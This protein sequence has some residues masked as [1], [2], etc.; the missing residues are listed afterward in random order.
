MVKAKTILLIIGLV[1]LAVGFTVSGAA[2]ALAGFDFS[3][4]SSTSE[5]IEKSAQWTTDEVSLID[6]KVQNANVIVEKSDDELIHI[7]CVFR[8]SSDLDLRLDGSAATVQGSFE[9]SFRYQL[10]HGFFSGLG[11]GDENVTIYIPENAH[12]DLRLVTSNSTISVNGFKNAESTSL[13]VCSTSNGAINLTDVEIGGA[14]Q[15]KSSNGRI[16]ARSLRAATLTADTSNGQISIEDAALSG[17]CDLE[18]SNGRVILKNVKCES[19]NAETNNGRINVSGI[20]AASIVLKSS[21]G[22]IEGT[23][24]GRYED[25][26][27]STHTS[28][29]S[30]KP[31]NKDSGK[32][33]LDVRTSNGDIHLSFES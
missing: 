6:V 24:S 30:R 13:L 8:E 33:S 18:T 26:R 5:M 7:H 19:I 23:V 22:D 1:L 10:V 27:I 28:N 3:S 17:R 4:V 21:N 32:Y 29:G 11:S 14:A 15:L 16:N 20:G 12:T 2:F 9:H 25:Y 31:E